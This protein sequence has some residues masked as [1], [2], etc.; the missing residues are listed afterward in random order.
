M[1]HA[2]LGRNEL[3]FEAYTALVITETPRNSLV[4][5]SLSAQVAVFILY[6]SSVGIGVILCYMCD[7][8]D[9][10]NMKT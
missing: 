10:I 1:W 3:P 5:S 7:I 9:L 2:T 8:L 4:C 6:T